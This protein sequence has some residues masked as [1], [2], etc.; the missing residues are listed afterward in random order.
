MYSLANFDLH[1]YFDETIHES[2]GKLYNDDG[3]TREAYEKGKYEILNFKSKLKKDRLFITVE[4]DCGEFYKSE[5]KEIQFVIHNISEAPKKVE[6]GRLELP[7]KWA[8]GVLKVQSVHNQKTKLK[9][10]L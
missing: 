1:F 8:N 7:F 6:L 9:I 4:S 10:C 5:N 3:L 2:E